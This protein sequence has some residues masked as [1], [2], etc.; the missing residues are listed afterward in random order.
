MHLLALLFAQSVS[1]KKNLAVQKSLLQTKL[2]WS[3]T[4][5]RQRAFCKHTM[6]RSTAK[7]TVQQQCPIIHPGAKTHAVFCVQG[8]HRIIIIPWRSMP[9][10]VYATPGSTHERRNN[11]AAKKRDWYG[12]E[13]CYTLPF[14][15]VHNVRSGT[16]PPPFPYDL[17]TQRNSFERC[18]CCCY[19]RRRPRICFP[20]APR[21]LRHHHKSDLLLQPHHQG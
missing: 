18:C 12:H 1:Q 7:R 20:I 16:L 10:G 17:V 8:V 6:P 13:R 11:H 2:P 15:S 4:L 9:Y 19:R 21:C 3:H 14:F 5:A